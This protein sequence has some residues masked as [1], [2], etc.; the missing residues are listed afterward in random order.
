M[1]TWLEEPRV[2]SCIQQIILKPMVYLHLGNKSQKTVAFFVETKENKKR[3][4]CHLS[5]KLFVHVFLILWKYLHVSLPSRCS[6]MFI[7]LLF[8][9]L[10]IFNI[11]LQN[12]GFHYGTKYIFN[13]IS[14][15]LYTQ[16]LH[17]ISTF[18]FPC[19]ILHSPF[20]PQ[21]YDLF[22]LLHTYHNTG[23]HTYTLQS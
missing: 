19:L 11:L 16:V 2:H 13:S 3:D 23:T 9:F 22:L 8:L 21:I 12:N 17:I 7:Y 5:R 10:L 4:S 20:P 1:L 18:T 14:W 6:F 15:E